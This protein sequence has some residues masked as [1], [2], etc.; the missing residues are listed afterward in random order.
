MSNAVKNPQE[1]PEED[2][3]QISGGTHD[4]RGYKRAACPK[5]K[6]LV[7]GKPGMSAICP[8]CGTLVDIVDVPK[9]TII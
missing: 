5:C 2:A 4:R 8:Y 6:K 9:T 7:T 3:E 1:L